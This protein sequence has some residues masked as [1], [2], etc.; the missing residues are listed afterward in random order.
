[1]AAAVKAWTAMEDPNLRLRKSPKSA[2]ILWIKSRYK[3]LK[4]FH[5]KDNLKSGIK[6][7]TINISAVER[8]ATIANW[9]PGGGANKTPGS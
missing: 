8:A 9:L 4:L 3:E 1:M 5:E 6:A 2:M 7:G